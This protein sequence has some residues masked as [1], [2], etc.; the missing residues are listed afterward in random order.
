MDER[1]QQKSKRA[2]TGFWKQTCEVCNRATYWSDS[3][4]L[5]HCLDHDT[6]PRFKGLGGIPEQPTVETTPVRMDKSLW[7]KSKTQLESQVV[8]LSPETTL[9]IVCHEEVDKVMSSTGKYFLGTQFVKSPKVETELVYGEDGK[10]E[11]ETE[12]VTQQTRPIGRWL[13]GTICNKCS[14][15]DYRTITK[16][17]KV[18]TMVKGVATQVLEEHYV[19]RI[20]LD[21]PKVMERNKMGK[22]VERPHSSASIN[23]GWSRSDQTN[24]DINWSPTSELWSPPTINR[25]F[26]RKYPLTISK[27]RDGFRQ[28]VLREKVDE[29]K[30]K[31]RP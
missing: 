23:P 15:S 29:A 17:R 24:E 5:A 14:S 13:K 28:T 20:Q 30:R 19:P 10:L 16:Y 8:K 21:T 18:W 3:T 11:S 2:N 1:V 31:L 26:D 6:W 27:P 7:G 25:V 22:M 4:G 9:C 12:V